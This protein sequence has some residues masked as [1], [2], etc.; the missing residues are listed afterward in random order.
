MQNG[1][2]E[3]TFQECVERMTSLPEEQRQRLFDLLNE[4]RQRQETLLRMQREVLDAID[5]WRISEKYRAFDL[6]CRQRESQTQ[7]EFGEDSDSEF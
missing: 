4:S 3:T 7:A 2:I 5:D 1:D 6:E